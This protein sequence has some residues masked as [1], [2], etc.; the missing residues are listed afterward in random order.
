M[1]Q[2]GNFRPRVV[3][4]IETRID[5]GR[6]YSARQIDTS[7]LGDGGTFSVVLTNP[8][9]SGVFILT[10]QPTVRVT[11]EAFFEK[12]ENPTVDTAGE[13]V[14]IRNKRVGYGRTA[15]STAQAGG[16]NFT[17]V[18]SGGVS[19]GREIVGGQSSK[20]AGSLGTIDLSN[21]LDPGES[22][23]Y[24]IESNSSSNLASIALAFVEE[25]G[26]A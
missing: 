2:N 11:G 14:T 15:E 26:T 1:V 7:G 22:I 9:D 3:A 18:F 13:S 24:K 8:V 16:T 19:K 25:P 4:D 23:Q 17:G 21:R 5:N 10:A 6:V 12:I 20:Q